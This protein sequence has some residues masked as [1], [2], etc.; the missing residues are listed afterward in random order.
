MVQKEV[1]KKTSIYAT[2]AVLFALILVSMVYVYGA[3]PVAPSPSSQLPN[4]VSNNSPVPQPS[5]SEIFQSGHNRM[6]T[7]ASMEE[8]KSYL[9]NNTLSGGEYYGAESLGIAPTATQNTFTNGA[10]DDYSTTNVQ[11]AGV[12]EADTVKTDGQYIYT[13]SAKTSVY[14]AT[15]STSPSNTVYIVSADPQN[16]RVVSKI[17]FDAYTSP[18]G[19]FLSADSTRLVVFTS[20]TQFY[21]P[22]SPIAMIVPLY[23]TGD[24]SIDIYDISNKAT[25]VLTENFTV[26]GSYVS[27]RMIGNNVYAVTTQTAYMSNDTVTVPTVYTTGSAVTASPTSIYYAD[28]NKSN[29]FSFTS[30]YGFDVSKNQTPTNLTVLIN[31]ASTMYVSPNNI[32]LAY[33]NW[34]NNQYTSLYRVKINGLQLSFEAQGTVPGY[35]INQYAL[36][37]YNGNLRVATEPSTVHINPNLPE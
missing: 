31:G 36:D 12:D 6:K 16:S 7:F 9:A 20:R 15:T 33:P 18:L 4:I 24:T 14:T 5:I 8:L 19:L 13:V 17:N 26:S 35:I 1:K 3:G 37:E 27:S 23:Y 22:N 34:N 11:V 25:P 30:F 2:A 32:Y 10:T 21:Y 28:M 29:E